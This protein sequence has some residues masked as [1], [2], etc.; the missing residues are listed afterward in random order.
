MNCMV[1]ALLSIH[2]PITINVVLKQLEVA[3]RKLGVVA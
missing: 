2:P 1:Y 3:S